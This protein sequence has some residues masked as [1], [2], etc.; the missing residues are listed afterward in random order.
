M[1][2]PDGTTEISTGAFFLPFYEEYTGETLNLDFFKRG[3][4]IEG[5][6]QEFKAAVEKIDELKNRNWGLYWY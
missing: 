2:I 3:S 1:F 6:E 4:L 5:K